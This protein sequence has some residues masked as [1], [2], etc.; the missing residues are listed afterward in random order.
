MALKTSAL[1]HVQITSRYSGI[2]RN[3]I[4]Y[5]MR[6]YFTPP[7]SYKHT[8]KTLRLRTMTGARFRDNLTDG[9]LRDPFTG[10]SHS[11]IYQDCTP[12]H[13][14]RAPQVICSFRAAHDDLNL[15]PIVIVRI[16]HDAYDN[17]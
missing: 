7:A 1:T 9:T 12:F 11:I 3:L 15:E 5:I 4:N 17:S 13:V 6:N 10:I 2:S 14:K 8:M 16:Y